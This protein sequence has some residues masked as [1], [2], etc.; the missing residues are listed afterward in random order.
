M[1]VPLLPHAFVAAVPVLDSD[2]TPLEPDVEPGRGRPGDAARA[3]QDE[4]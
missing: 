2:L 1:H 3:R 4:P